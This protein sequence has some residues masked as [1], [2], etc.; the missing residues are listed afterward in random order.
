HDGP[1]IMIRCDMDAL[2]ITEANTTDYIAEAAGNMHACGHDGHTAIGLAV[3]KMLAGQKDRI[4]GRVKFV[5]QPAE[6]T[7]FG[8]QEMI[9][10]GVLTDPA[11]QVCVGLHLRNDM[12]LGEIGITEG[13]IMSGSDIFAITIRGSGGHGALPEQTRDPI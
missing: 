8:A 6:E 11:P 5:F 10:D 13:P 4:A 3:A 9:K 12:P 1:T 7:G 2:P